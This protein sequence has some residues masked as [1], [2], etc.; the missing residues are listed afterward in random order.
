MNGLRKIPII[1]YHIKIGVLMAKAISFHHTSTLEIDP[2]DLHVSKCESQKGQNSGEHNG[3]SISAL[4]Q[5]R[6][7][8]GPLVF[9]FLLFT[10]CPT[11]PPES[12]MILTSGVIS[13][14]ASRLVGYV[15]D[16]SRLL[17]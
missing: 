1:E 12:V 5:L 16:Y 14:A 15:Y 3:T 17:F 7:A 10:A 4:R 11:F 8:E 2:D 6:I 13:P 9:R